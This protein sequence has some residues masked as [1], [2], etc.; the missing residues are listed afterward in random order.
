MNRTYTMSS[1][2]IFLCR[3]GLPQLPLVRMIASEVGFRPSIYRFQ[4]DPKLENW[5]IPRQHR[6]VC[7]IGA[8]QHPGRFVQSCSWREHALNAHMHRYAIER[9][10]RS[11]A[12]LP[13]RKDILRF[14][15]PRKR[16]YQG[17]APSLGR[18]LQ[19]C[20]DPAEI[21]KAPADRW[22]SSDE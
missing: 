3:H 9:A 6:S 18:L 13:P 4:T 14:Q 8:E 20:N 17:V 15:N 22:S 12:T 16:R 11:S 19:F 10:N 2:H 5:F 1:R 7:A 21:R